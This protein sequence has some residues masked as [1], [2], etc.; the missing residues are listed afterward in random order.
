LNKESISLNIYDAINFSK[1]AWNSVSQ[2]T[3]FNCWKY[4]GILSQNEMDNEIE[5]HDD[6]T[7]CD[8]MEL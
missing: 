1:D 5:D 2:Q 8:E 4:T 6:Q 7:V 3:I